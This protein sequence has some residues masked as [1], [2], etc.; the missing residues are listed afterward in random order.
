MFEFE[1]YSTSEPQTAC[2]ECQETQETSLTLSAELSEVKSALSQK[3][4]EVANYASTT[5]DLKNELLASKKKLED[6]TSEHKGKY[7]E[8]T[9]K[10]EVSMLCMAYLIF[11]LIIV[12]ILVCIVLC[13]CT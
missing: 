7:A 1:V 6:S 12:H 3:E 9:E 11:V 4:Q 2:A 8:L 13:E 5:E 10:C